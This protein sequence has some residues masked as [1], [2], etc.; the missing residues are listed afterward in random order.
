MTPQHFSA[1]A[2]A[3]AIDLYVRTGLRA[4]T[5]YSPTNM[6]RAAKQIT[7]K[8]FKRNQLADA[9]IALRAYVEKELGQ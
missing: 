6:L 3:S 8:E 1:L 9:A 7:G 4:N 5:S 2:I